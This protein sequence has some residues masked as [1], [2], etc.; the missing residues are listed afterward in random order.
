MNYTAT[1]TDALAQPIADFIL[2]VDIEA[3]DPS[4]VG[5]TIAE[6]MAMAGTLDLTD[7]EWAATMDGFHRDGAN[8]EGLGEEID[9][10]GAAAL[11]A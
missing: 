2:S 8:I 5:A 11:Q 3:A 6:A 9:W 1:T 10:M 7:V 4:T